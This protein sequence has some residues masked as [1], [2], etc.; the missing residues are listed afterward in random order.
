MKKEQTQAYVQKSQGQVCTRPCQPES[1]WCA[2]NI[3]QGEELA[4][5][6]PGLCGWAGSGCKQTVCG[7]TVNAGALTRGRLCSRDR[8]GKPCQFPVG[9]RHRTLVWLC[10]YQQHKF[11]Q[12]FTWP[13]YV[14]PKLPWLLTI[15]IPK[16]FT[17]SMFQ[18]QKYFYQRSLIGLNSHSKFGD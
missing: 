2:L 13:L 5:K 4:S 6:V 12:G 16:L 3:A 11:T 15:H 1:S 9:L 18:P 8:G 7:H 10:S 17:N 14:H